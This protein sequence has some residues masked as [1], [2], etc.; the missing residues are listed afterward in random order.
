MR[1]GWTLCLPGTQSHERFF[2]SMAQLKTGS[3]RQ[4]SCRALEI[5]QAAES[6]LAT[7]VSTG[8]PELTP[9]GQRH[10]ENSTVSSR[11]GNNRVSIA[12]QAYGRR[13]E[14]VVF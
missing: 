1:S 11:G 10:D 9:V 12:S 3:R 14:V 4:E 8:L 5:V 7:E 6:F 13:P 2:L